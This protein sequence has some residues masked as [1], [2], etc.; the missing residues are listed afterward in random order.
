MGQALIRKVAI[1][2]LRQT[3][4]DMGMSPPVWQDLNG[5]F[6]YAI[7]HLDLG[8]INRKTSI[9]GIWI[10]ADP[11]LEKALFN[12]VKN[13]VLHAKTATEIRFTWRESIDG[14]ILV[15][16]DNGIGILPE[17]KDTIFAPD[18]RVSKG[19]GL[20]FVREILSLTEITIEETGEPGK[21]ARFEMTVPKG[22]W[23]IAGDIK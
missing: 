20:F 1:D 16:E 8:S 23:R 2:R 6:L 12:L 21:G 3:H 15:Y 9:Q 7:S 4:Q 14:L 18:I 5:V 19:F 13:T 17:Q 10:F 11:M 22:M